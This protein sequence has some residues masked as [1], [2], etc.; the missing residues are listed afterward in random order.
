MDLDI[1]KARQLLITL[2]ES[3]TVDL[4]YLISSRDDQIAKPRLKADTHIVQ[5]GEIEICI[6]RGKLT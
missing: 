1:D 6:G 5:G 4:S 3:G 2:M